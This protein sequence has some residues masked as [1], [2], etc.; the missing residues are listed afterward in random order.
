MAAKHRTRAQ[1]EKIQAQRSSVPSYAFKSSSV[2]AGSSVA[3]RVT[4]KKAER[5]YA[6][7]DMFPYDVQL[8]YQDLRKTVM[9]TGILFTLLVVL[10][11][12]FG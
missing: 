3:P 12:R 2:E 1:K 4:S 6:I 8:I 10:R 9:I 5:S 11:L 7:A